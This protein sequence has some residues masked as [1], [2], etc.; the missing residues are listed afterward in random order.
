MESVGILAG[1]IAHD[2]NNILTGIMGNIGLAKIFVVPAGQASA[3]LVEAEEAALRAKGLTQQLLTFARGGLP[4]RKSTSIAK[5]LRQSAGFA[6]RGSRVR[7]K[8]TLPDDLWS[9][10]IDEGQINQVITNLVIN[11][12]EAMP[13]GGVVK[14]GA[15]NT[16]IEASSVLPLPEGNYIEITVADHGIGIS[17]EH[18]ARIFEPYFTT[19]QKGSGLGLATAYSII[20]NHDGYIT[21]ESEL[22]VGTTFHIYFPASGKPAPKKEKLVAKAAVAGEGRI[23]VMDDEE[24]LRKMLSMTLP[25]DGYEVELARDGAEAVELYK[26]ARESGRPFDAVILDLTVPGGMGG[27]EAIK[28]LLEIYPRV[29]AI[30]SS[31]Y[32]TD[33]VMADFKDYGFSA[34]AVKPYRIEELENTLRSLI[35]GEK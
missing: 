26:K 15:K 21:A 6:L 34:V 33:P 13:E 16:T 3:A 25:L 11:A 20:R 24:M 9:V 32:S 35:T 22:S 30:V 27:K 5:L 14:I 18:L 29:K 17:P 8:F 10:E 23:L 28:K 1:G 12:D 19:K 4:I 2:F 31:G 7:G